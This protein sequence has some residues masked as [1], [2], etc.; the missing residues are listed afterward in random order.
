[1]Q[2]YGDAA[3]FKKCWLRVTLKDANAALAKGFGVW[4]VT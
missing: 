3:W 4:S 1:L 2:D